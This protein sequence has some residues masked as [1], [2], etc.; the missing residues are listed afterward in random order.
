M[1]KLLIAD[2]ESRIRKGLRNSFDWENFN[3]QVIGEAE[4]GE[5][6]LKLTEML[7]PDIMLLDICMPFLNGLELIKELKAKDKECLIIVITGHDEFNYMHEALKLQVFDY[8]LK[9]VNKEELTETLNNAVKE[10]SNR[11]KK[12]VQ[13]DWTNK[14]LDENI[15]ALEK[16]FL[17]NWFSG[18]LTKDQILNE[19]DFFKS[20]IENDITMLFIKPIERLNHEIYSK[21]WDKE[22]LSFAIANLALE[23]I[24][25]FKPVFTYIDE[26]N[27][28]VIICNCCCINEWLHIENTIVDRI[29]SYLHCNVILQHRKISD[30]ILG[31][32]KNYKEIDKEMDKYKEYKPVVLLATRFINNNYYSKN[33]SLETISIKFNVSTSYLSKLLKQDTGLSFIDYLTNIRINKAVCMMDDPRLKVYEIAEAVGY[34]DQHYFCKAFK[35][36]KGY[37]PSE[38]RGGRF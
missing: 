14:Q 30:S 15:S 3:I 34:S 9:P 8:I 33:L 19:V 6:A 38:Y 31:I 26:K 25:E 36:V 12:K 32:E 22:L 5:V 11:E 4:D 10:L 29:Y 23:I 16:S 20:N 37:S 17:Q 24:E 7:M 35:R 28:I 18:K 1:Y 13:L 27:S 2:D 21:G